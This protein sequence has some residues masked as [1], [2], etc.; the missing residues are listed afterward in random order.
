MVMTP[1]YFIADFQTGDFL[2][3]VRLSGGNFSSNHKPGSFSATIDLRRY[4]SMADGRG[5]IERLRDG[6][7][8]LVM[9]REEVST[10]ADSPPT[11]I[12]LG[13][14][15]ISKVSGS[16]RSP[17][18]TI[19][20]PEFE[21]YASYAVMVDRFVGASVDPVAATRQM[22]WDLYTTNQNI[23]VNL[24]EWIS[25]TGARVAMNL[26]ETDQDYWAAIKGLQTAED[27]PFEWMMRIGLVLNGWNPV[28]VTRTLEVG[29]PEL[30]LV[31]DDI[32]LEVV[33]P[34]KRGGTILDADWSYDE[35]DSATTVYGKGAGS[36]DDQ[37]GAG[38]DVFTSRARKPGEPVKTFTISVQD[39]TTDAQLR[40]FTRAELAA[41]SPRNQVFKAQMPTDRYT[42][43]K[44]HRYRWFNDESWTMPRSGDND[45]VRCAGWSWRVGAETYDLDLARV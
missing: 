37:V 23:A 33:G 15:W 20:G 36:G 38:G 41:S 26:R 5:L 7:C 40:G 17:I 44:G 22:L 10:G 18:L 32:S 9:V 25:H 39:A 29:Q 14:W 19:G 11:S 13:E 45:R 2:E 43:V 30:A 6:K 4:P 12:A 27:G 34:G 3:R 21:G 16:Y 8:S 1:S 24:Q 28:R 31:R 42:P 35:A